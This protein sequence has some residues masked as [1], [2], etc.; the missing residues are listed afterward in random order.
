M[1]KQAKQVV[2]NTSPDT[3][4]SKYALN[5]DEAKKISKFIS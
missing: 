5:D 2:R 1:I 4:I 3:R